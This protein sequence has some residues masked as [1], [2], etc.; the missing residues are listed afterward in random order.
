MH[1]EFT[2]HDLL[3]NSLERDPAKP[4]VEDGDDS[5]SYADLD[6]ESDALAAAFLE[7]GLRRGQ[8]LGVYMEKSWEA[9]VAMLAASKAGAAFVNINPLLKSQQVSYIVGDCDVQVLIGESERLANLDNG[10]VD[11]AFHKGD[12]APNVAK[13]SHDLSGV[14]KVSSNLLARLGCKR[15]PS[16]ASST[17]R[18]RRGC[19]KASPSATAT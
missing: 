15:T 5:H 6:R 17:L 12:E 3:A 7:N 14:Y 16:V 11:T 13:T 9:I 1:H 18:S 8:R 2:F 19:P 10:L 4:A